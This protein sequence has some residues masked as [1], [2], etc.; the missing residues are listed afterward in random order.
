M[1]ENPPE[2]KAKNYSFP[3]IT[4]TVVTVSDQICEVEFLD[5]K[6]QIGQILALETDP[7]T[8]MEVVNSKETGNIIC[9]ILGSTK[10]LY[11][12]AKVIYASEGLKV[13]VGRPTLGRLMNLFGEPIDKKGSINSRFRRPIRRPAPPLSEISNKRKVLETGIKAIDFFAPF[14]YGGKIGLVGGAGLGKT[15]LLTEI[16]HNSAVWQ[17]GIAVFAGIGE[18]LREGK[19]LYDLLEFNKILQN[20]ALVFGQMNENASIRYRVGFTAAA[21]A[22]YFRDEENH[23]VLFFI[24]NMYRF[25]QA[26]NELST[27][28]NSIPS[29]DGYQS[30]L[31]SEMA[32]LQERIVSTKNAA[33]T[34]VQAIYVPSDDVTDKAVTATFPH[35]DSVVILSRQVA[36]AGRYPAI[37][38]LNS[39]SN[40]LDPAIIG[41]LHYETLI[42]AQKILKQYT[43]LERIVAIVG[44]SELSP[45]SQT[46]Y[47]RA[48]KLINYM[49]QNL[50][51]IQEFIGRRGKYVK[52]EATVADV[53]QIVNGKLDHLE[54]EKLLDI[55]SLADLNKPIVN[56]QAAN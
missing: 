16:I 14:S 4:G 10:N 24:D 21:I 46:I 40:L 45:E 20:V 33:I 34:S 8:T 39:S 7:T 22:E 1:K 12:G 48:I 29:Q 28:M 32:S 31:D 13:P 55:G 51:V 37:D 5:Q 36:E 26:G 38:L 49:T 52:K 17:K 19:D 54:D 25:I 3:Q 56:R 6:P 30:T 35:L 47:H 27:Q 2:P 23:D 41:K 44:E 53:A 43:D 50:F 9:I 15:V 18:R 11:R 42:T